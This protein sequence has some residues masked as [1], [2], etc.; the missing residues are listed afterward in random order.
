[1]LAL[2]DFQTRIV[3]QIRTGFLEGHK[4]QLLAAATGSG[5]T[6]IVSVMIHKAAK[7]GNR[8]LFVVDRIELVEQAARHLRGIG[9]NVGIMQ[10][11][12]T[13]YNPAN[14][15]L[16][17]TIQTL[18]SRGVPYEFKMMIIDETHILHKHHTKVMEDNPEAYVIGLSA[19]PLRED[20]GNFYSN[21]VRGPTPLELIE[22]GYL[23]RP[24]VF[25]PN[26]EQIESLLE[27][28]AFDHRAGDYRNSQLSEK[29]NRKELIGDI[30]ATWEKKAPGLKTIVFCVDVAH[31]KAVCDDFLNAGV[32][33]EQLDYRTK[34]DDRAEIIQRFR[35]G[36]TTVLTSVN[37]LGIGFDVP[38]V[39]CGIMARPT[40]SLALFIQQGGRILRTAPGKDKTILLDHAGNVHRFGLLENF[41]VPDL[42]TGKHKTSTKR[43][44]PDSL[45]SCSECGAVM[46][47]GQ[48]ICPACG[49]EQPERQTDV[50]YQDGELSEWGK[51]LERRA[52]REMEQQMRR[53][54]YCQFKWFAKRKGHKPGWA[55][56]KYK[57]KFGH[58]PPWDWKDLP[59][60]PMTEEVKRWLQSQAIRW[61]KGQEKSAKGG[62]KAACRRCGSTGLTRGPGKGPH[63]ASA[64]CA[65]CGAHVRWLAKDSEAGLSMET[66]TNGDRRETEASARL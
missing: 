53:E 10:G 51:A 57:A 50:H 38:D 24:T 28:V 48:R 8:S 55:S 31:S 36:E 21:L 15:V 61:R 39:Q 6:V 41:V 66:V 60:Q 33:A 27:D 23:V 20:L 5:K 46:E 4:R 40:A 7:R 9:L 3:D 34:K 44:K 56:F 59:E 12:N 29:L 64:L 18:A 45:Q 25:A 26:R 17:C 47:A 22:M 1:M 2:Y 52:E 30:I 11:E 16:V 63:A 54:W 37:V 65:N 43:P 19:T 35:D 13:D 62:S 32:A 14:E 42:G 49:I 58:F